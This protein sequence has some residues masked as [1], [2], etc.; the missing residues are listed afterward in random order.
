VATEDQSAAQ[1]A[2]EF[3]Q[4]LNL[5]RQGQSD[6]AAGCLRRAIALAPSF[7]EA[8]SALGGILADCGEYR[9]AID[10]FRQVVTLTPLAAE[11]HYNLG[12]ALAR[13]GRASEALDSYDRALE[14][15]PGWAE[16][17]NNRAA[18]LAGL[19]RYDESAEAC[20]RALELKP[21]YAEARFNLG[22]AVKSC[23]P[24]EA[25]ACYRQA[26]ALQPNYLEA[27][28]NLAV[29]LVEA[30]RPQE[31]LVSYR[32]TIE[33]SPDHVDAHLGLAIA[34]LLLGRFSEG[35]PEY[36]W[37]LRHPALG[38]PLL[39]EPAWTGEPLGGRT[40]LVRCEQGLGDAVQFARYLPLVKARGGRL[41]LQ[42]PQPLV[43][44]F[45]RG[46]SIDRLV[47]RGEALPPFDVQAA[48]LSLPGIFATTLETIPAG[49]PYL[50]PDGDAVSRWRK[51][52][53]ADGVL[54]VGIA[55]QGST[56]NP[57]DRV[58]SIPLERFGP[59][60]R[61]PGVRL[62]SLQV[63]AGSEQL[64][65]LKGDVPLVDLGP[66]IADLHDMAAIMCNLDL[67]VTCDSAPAHVAG[68]IGRPVWVALPNAADWRWLLARTDSPWYP[69][70]RLFRQPRAGDW[71][72][73][74]Q[75]IGNELARLAAA[76][77]RG[78]VLGSR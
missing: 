54:K 12:L 39:A 57:R 61:L 75:A 15:K 34:L 14:R 47:P 63:G 51:E 43:R 6:A 46:L 56:R 24:E 27:H 45:E 10:C 2:W 17:H 40:I 42:C 70:M 65:A 23:Q 18:V 52:L 4:G 30:N 41:V 67:V 48:L 28:Y 49:G 59:L 50:T 35:W 36:E 32:R 53:G 76:P 26:L 37:R 78:G 31:A 3:A 19:A 58:R 20:R 33:L 66:R 38:L 73:V 13:A 16:A 74:L 21:D 25:L 77:P 1:A 62:Y 8:Y 5:A 69:T 71:Q 60:A 29:A 68:A 55:W 44:L 72:G 11:A 9:E 22:L 7:A 64:A